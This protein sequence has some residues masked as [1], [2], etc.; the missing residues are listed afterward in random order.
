MSSNVDKKDLV[1]SSEE[2]ES[3]EKEVVRWGLKGSHEMLNP[4]SVV[5]ESNNYDCWVET[6]GKL[7]WFNWVSIDFD[8]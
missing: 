1:M 6:E 4:S 3:E 8:D 2:D 7:D 5:V